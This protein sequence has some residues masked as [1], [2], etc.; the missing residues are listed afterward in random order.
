MSS[1]E[2]ED[3][4]SSVESEH[5]PGH[6]SPSPKRHVEAFATYED[7]RDK[8]KILR[9]CFKGLSKSND[10]IS[11]A[12]CCARGK[13]FK[14]NGEFA[15][16]YVE[17]DDN[18][19]AAQKKVWGIL[20]KDRKSVTEAEAPR[21]LVADSEGRLSREQVSNK[22]CYDRRKHNRTF[23]ADPQ[24]YLQEHSPGTNVHCEETVKFRCVHVW[25]EELLQRSYGRILQVDGTFKVAPT[26]G[27]VLNVGVNE[28]GTFVPVMC[29]VFTPKNPGSRATEGCEDLDCAFVQLKKLL[30]PR[31][32]PEAIMRDMGSAYVGSLRKA[33]PNT[34][35]VVCYFHVCDSA[36]KWLKK[37]ITD[38]ALRDLALKQMGAVHFCKSQEEYDGV[39]AL[40]LREIRNTPL[41][42]FWQW[43]EATGKVRTGANIGWTL[44]HSRLSTNSTI[45]RFNRLMNQIKKSSG[46]TTR[47]ACVAA[48][49]ILNET[50]KLLQNADTD[51]DSLY[52]EFRKRTEKR[53]VKQSELAS[54]E[55]IRL[56]RLPVNGHLVKH[57][58]I[59]FYD[60]VRGPVLIKKDEYETAHLQRYTNWQTYM[61]FSQRCHRTTEHD[62][63]CRPFALSSNGM[64]PHFFALKFHTNFYVQHV[65]HDEEPPRILRGGKMIAKRAREVMFFLNLKIEFL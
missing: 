14:F 12:K 11:C 1:T 31:Y 9:M 15:V 10:Y 17:H 49:E 64:C 5:S 35:Q 33:F 38:P 8:V 44:I 21:S 13:I 6:D 26:G 18:C 34:P 46:K 58:E 51:G 16:E 54:A 41:H 37:N 30:G 65:E 61:D 23:V 19:A 60:D 59:F 53:L 42:A 63:T 62:C 48:V 40:L 39:L 36:Q 50:S 20:N 43:M 55:Y 24:E 4:M 52:F 47:D 3:S 7:A 45:E 2:R 57:K 28:R 22:R 32:V 27:Y 29:S 56:L 25:R